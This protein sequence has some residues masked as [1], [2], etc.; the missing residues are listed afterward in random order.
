LVDFNIPYDQIKRIRSGEDLLQVL[1]NFSH[2]LGSFIST[3]IK[4]HLVVRKFSVLSKNLI[5]SAC[6]FGYLLEHFQ[7]FSEGSKNILRCSELYFIFKQ[8]KNKA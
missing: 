8:E 3:L 4:K 2:F 7:T 1:T 5:S 6:I